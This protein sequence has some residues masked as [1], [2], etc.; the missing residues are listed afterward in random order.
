MTKTQIIGRAAALGLDT[1]T[2]SNG[3]GRLYRFALAGSQEMFHS[4]EGLHTARGA[5]AAAAFLAGYAAAAWNVHRIGRAAVGHRVSLARARVDVAFAAESV[6]A[7]ETLVGLELVRADGKVARLFVGARW[8]HQVSDEPAG[9]ERTGCRW[10]VEAAR[11]GIGDEHA[12]SLP[13]RF[14]D[15][16]EPGDVLEPTRCPVDALRVAKAAG[17]DPTA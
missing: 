12:T 11:G 15:Y 17:R 8:Y 14:V 1:F 10:F 3:A 5:A 9:E 16:T 7:G 13:G 4:G 6:Q 2:H